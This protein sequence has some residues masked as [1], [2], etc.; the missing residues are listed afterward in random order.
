M[1]FPSSHGAPK[2][3]F[4]T[5][6]GG[7]R[8]KKKHNNNNPRAS[9]EVLTFFIIRALILHPVAELGHAADLLAVVVR[10][11]VGV[12]L[13]GWVDSVLLDAAVEIFVFLD[14]EWSFMELA[15]M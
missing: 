6:W 3:A 12:G 8:K 9:Q 13:A 5:V 7:E 1:V 2:F 11:G 4:S 10:D 15:T 14:I